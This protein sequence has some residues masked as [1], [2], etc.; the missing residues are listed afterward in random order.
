MTGLNKIRLFIVVLIITGGIFGASSVFAQ[1]EQ[2]IPTWVKTAVAF[3]VND[4]ISDEEFINVIQY[5]VENEIIKV[6]QAKNGGLVDNLLTFQNEL[7]AKIKKSQALSNNA[8]IRKSIIESNEEFSKISVS[9]GVDIREVIQESDKEWTATDPKELTPFM[10]ELINNDAAK[11][12][13]AVVSNDKKSGSVFTFE[14]IFVTNEFG[15]N[16]AYE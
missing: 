5:F 15:A 10:L 14:E 6:P 13:K 2:L 12:L 11:V 1:Q 16:V 9:G 8:Q 7:N 3:W 4:Q